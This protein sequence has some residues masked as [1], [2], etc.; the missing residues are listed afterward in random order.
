MD[1]FCR[2]G[3]M[4]I[5][6]C[7]DGS[8]R[9]TCR[10]CTTSRGDGSR[11]PSATPD[12]G[13]WDEGARYHHGM[14]VRLRPGTKVDNAI[15]ELERLSTNSY[16]ESSVVGHEHPAD[17]QN[18]YVLWTTRYEQQLLGILDRSEVVRWLESERHSEICTM[19]IGN[20]A[21]PMINAEV[22][23]KASH[24]RA[25]ADG[26]K[27]ARAD[28]QRAPGC[29]TVVDTNLL[30][31]YQRPDNVAWSSIIREQARLM[32]PLRV[33]EELDAKKFD[34]KPRLR[35]AARSLLPWL[36]GLVP[37]GTRGP[38]SLSASDGTTIEILLEE[39]PRYRPNDADEEILD[40]CHN[41]E[42]LAGRAKLVTGDTCMRLRASAEG[43]SVYAMPEKYER[44]T[45]V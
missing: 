40:V 13:S 9:P 32:V 12:V 28:M 11:H 3:R 17:R 8:G 43:L 22:T 1:G 2:W 25:L 20:H 34:P 10:L 19:T 31:E 29:P 4:L 21:I 18:D 7:L 24:L 45:S 37:T 27:E 23:T 38:E 36:E 41:V 35:A 14:R 33:I 6:G 16:V 44:A 30:L 15:P 39:R 5:L 26:L 42:L